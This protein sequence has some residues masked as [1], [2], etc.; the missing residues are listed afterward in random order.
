[1]IDRRR[2]LAG[3]LALAAAPARAQT[4]PTRPIT[5]IVPF[6][7]GGS[8]DVIARVMAAGLRLELGQFVVI[9]NRAGAGGSLGTEAIAKAT[10]DGYTIGMGTASTLAINP[11][12][13][14]NL[15][16]DVLKDLAPIT[17]IAA[18]PN[19]M[20]IHPTVP[21]K[22]MAEFI[23]Y[24]KAQKGKL[25]Y[26]SSGNGSVAHLM[27]EQF[28][29]A[30]GTDLLH[31]AYRGI[32]PAMNDVV[33]GQVQVLFDNLPTT[34]PMVQSDKLRALAVSGAK[35]V[36]ALPNVPTFTEL[37][38]P[39]LEWMAFFGLIAPAGTPSDI[40]ARLRDAITRVMEQPD[41]RKALEVQQAILVGSAPNEFHGLIERELMRMKRAV[42]AANIHIDH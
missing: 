36:A 38:L 42:E 29:L 40:I 5:L 23:A 14:R 17:E 35:R 18:V 1:M 25:S 39:D 11:A 30:T 16:F 28:K 3:A 21:A 27:G 33:G 19:I 32:G 13:Y 34:L 6:A 41:V 26:A 31:V 22:D 10:P 8:T 37:G 9:E 15:P 2:L 20:S 4:Y 7:A 12:A 24:A